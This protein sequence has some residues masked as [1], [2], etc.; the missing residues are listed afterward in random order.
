LDI[1]EAIGKVQLIKISG[2]GRDRL[3][4]VNK[5]AALIESNRGN[6]ILERSMRAAEDFATIVIAEFEEDNQAGIESSLRAFQ[7]GVL[8]SD[9]F[10]SAQKY[11]ILSGRRLNPEGKRYTVVIEGHD[12]SGLVASITLTL[13][14]FGLNLDGTDSEVTYEPFSGTKKFTGSFDFTIPDGFDLDAFEAEVR[15]VAENNGLEVLYI[16]ELP[17]KKLTN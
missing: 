17:P 5:V 12:Q 15:Q 6:I 7:D 11:S 14:Q 8:G 4:I 10:V 9:F 13:L 2:I 1:L 16:K 3:G